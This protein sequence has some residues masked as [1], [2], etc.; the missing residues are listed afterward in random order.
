MVILALAEVP[1]RVEYTITALGSEMLD[2][3]APLWLWGRKDRPAVSRS[4]S[5]VRPARDSA[6]KEINQVEA[7]SVAAQGRLVMTVQRVIEDAC[8][9][10]ASAF[11]SSRQAFANSADPRVAA[12]AF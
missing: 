7:P 9:R 8:A 11:R 6:R 10:N 3:V 2:N 5:R 12:P 1:P 4:P